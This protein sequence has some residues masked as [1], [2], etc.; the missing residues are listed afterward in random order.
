MIGMFFTN[1]QK[2]AAF[3]LI[4]DKRNIE[5]ILYSNEARMVTFNLSDGSE[6]LMT[7]EIESPVHEALIANETLY[8]G[9]VNAEMQMTSEYEAK[10]IHI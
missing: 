3:S 4:D 10:I 8:V 2:M 1:A 7:T 5:S 9:N 6:E